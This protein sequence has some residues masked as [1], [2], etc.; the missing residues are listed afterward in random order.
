MDAPAHNLSI[1][2]NQY[3][4]GI[5]DRIQPVGHDNQRLPA[6]SLLIAC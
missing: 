4:V 3:L 5:A 1:G 2:N 6:T